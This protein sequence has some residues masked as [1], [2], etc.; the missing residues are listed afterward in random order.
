MIKALPI[1]VLTSTLA[2]TLQFGPHAAGAAAAALVAA[3][4]GLI[5]LRSSSGGP[6]AP[7]KAVAEDTSGPFL[8]GLGGHIAAA[9]LLRL[10]GAAVVNASS[11]W[12]SFG[13]DSIHWELLG[14]ALLDRSNGLYV[15]P[16][17]DRAIDQ[18]YL[19]VLLN[20]AAITVFGSARYP[21]AFLNAV[22]G[23]GAAV[24]VGR[25]AQQLYGSRVA[26]DATLVALYF[27]SLIL[28][29]TLNLREV[30]SLGAI[31]LVLISAQ[32]VKSR[33]APLSL[34]V[35]FGSLG[36]LYLLRPYLV[37]LLGAALLGALPI[38]TPRRIP[39]AMVALALIAA[40]MTAYGPEVGSSVTFSVDSLEDLHYLRQGLSYGGS[41]FSQDTDTRTLAGT[42]AYLPL[43]VARFL[44]SPFPW[45]VRSLTQLTALP[46]SVFVL[47]MAFGAT[48]QAI[49]DG[50]ERPS[51][52]SVPIMAFLI[53]S[54]AYGLVSGNEG[55][56]FR[57]RAQVLPI[58]IILWCAWRAQAPSR[59][60]P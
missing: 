42:L 23:T 33:F 60:P 10:L 43:G 31:L 28:W 45:S 11:L 12:L 17:L 34:A 40:V 20:S 2:A 51:H 53:I 36:A 21:I 26:R 57:H 6:S 19:F 41:A 55:T 15:V 59:P 52:L 47:V 9:L 35:L 32:R 38:T 7:V 4:L 49:R 37:A 58:L 8:H 30:W 39:Y 5:A 1:V 48:R 18:H 25:Y 27:P 16:E 44:F 50:L 56:A 24:L 3:V 29:S 14:Q 13:P 54:C 46:E 22:A